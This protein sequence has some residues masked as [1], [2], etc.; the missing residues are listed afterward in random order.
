[1][2]STNP[3][4]RELAERS[5]KLG[6]FTG[7]SEAPGMNIAEV[8]GLDSVGEDAFNPLET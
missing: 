1:M 2:V 8:P 4:P 3:D 5:H 6:A 7:Q